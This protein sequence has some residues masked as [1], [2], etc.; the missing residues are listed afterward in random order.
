MS[1]PNVTVACKRHP[2]RVGAVRCQRCEAPM[3]PSCMTQA[4][5]GFHCP[6]CV[7]GHQRQARPAQR[8][9]TRALG[10]TPPYVS[11]AIVAIC[12]AIYVWDIAQGTNPTS[13]G[14]SQAAIDLSLWA[15]AMDLNGEWY[16]AITAG[17]AHLG[18]FHIGFNMFLL[19]QLGRPLE[20]RFGNLTFA[21][22]WFTGILGGSLGALLVEPTSSAVG[23]SGAVFALM[24]FVAVLQRAAGVSLMSGGLGGLILLNV[25]F[26]FRPGISLG[27]HFG[28]LAIGALMGG[29]FVLLQRHPNRRATALAP[30]VFAGIGLLTFVGIIFAADRAVGLF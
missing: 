24:G 23:A 17:F 28:G 16:R 30:V 26:S 13:G 15:P 19:W 25:L 18:L 1:D 20:G 5:V 6:D 12:V 7:A 4:S 8:A 27:G 29:I 9:V 2:D 22:I 21:T 3:C 10:Q 14:G 11:Q